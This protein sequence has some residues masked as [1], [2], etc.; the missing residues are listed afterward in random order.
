MNNLESKKSLEQNASDV[1]QTSKPHEKYKNIIFDLGRVLIH[2]NPLEDP[3]AL[4]LWLQ[5]DRGVL[6]HEQAA[7]L[8][9][10]SVDKENFL[11]FSR[12]VVNF[13]LPIQQGVEILHQ[14]KAK[15]YQAYMLSNFQQGLFEQI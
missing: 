3:Q 1:L 6:T 8:M 13:M 14:V 5:I 10:A 4:Y 11:T 12:E 7:E 9:P 2:W 15:G